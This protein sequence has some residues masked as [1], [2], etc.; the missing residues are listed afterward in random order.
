MFSNGLIR[1]LAT[2][3]SDENSLRLS[4]TDWPLVLEANRVF[5]EKEAAWKGEPLYG[6][7]LLEKIRATPADLD[8]RSSLELC[9]G[10]GFLFFSF[11]DRFEF[12]GGSEF[13]DVSPL[14]KAA[15]ERRCAA[16]GI[17]A[18]SI[19]VGDIGHLPLANESKDLVY[20]HSFLHH[21]PDVGYYLREVA[22][23]L[24][25]GGRFIG[26]HEPTPTAPLLEAFPRPL[27][28]RADPGSLT[29]IWLIRPEVLG[30]LLREAGFSRV[31]I[32]FSN[33]LAS[34]LVTPIQMVLAKLGF[35][36]D[37]PMLLRLRILCNRL[38]RILPKRLRARCSPSLA[39][40]AW[41]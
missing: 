36:H 24:R 32:Q 28:R 25:P 38:D 41:K 39:V 6:K 18:P 26:F 29:D 37:R 17:C 16:C 30:A 20:G 12:A 13:I 23:V 31:E 35:R 15:F 14:Q 21:L 9:C 11:R 3:C 40:M 33:L 19:V 8:F 4:A 27:L 2:K 22:R 7:Y 5:E 10:N 1:K 34:F